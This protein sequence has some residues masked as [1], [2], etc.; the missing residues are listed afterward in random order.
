MFICKESIVT[1]TEVES[2]DIM[3]WQ[4]IASQKDI[5]NLMFI[6]HYLSTAK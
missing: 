2:L 3:V 4:L 6:P 1:E 5:Y